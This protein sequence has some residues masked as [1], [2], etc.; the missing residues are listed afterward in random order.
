MA[1]SPTSDGSEKRTA[2]NRPRRIRL[3][4]RVS[5]KGELERSVRILG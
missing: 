4:L 5:L 2:N 1:E 3:P